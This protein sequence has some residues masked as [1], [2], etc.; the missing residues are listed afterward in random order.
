[1]R[2]ADGDR[3][4][5]GRYMGASSSSER[6]EGESSGQGVLDI[7]QQLTGDLGDRVEMSLAEDEVGGAGSSSQRAAAEER[8]SNG[9][10]GD[11]DRGQ[12]ETG[13]RDEQG[14][15]SGD[16]EM[17]SETVQLLARL[18]GTRL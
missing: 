2:K 10:G 7:L 8:T 3:T 6:E 13:G 5:L 15:E 14:E 1:M 16:E 17:E 11:N 4:S 12:G 18:F 9:A